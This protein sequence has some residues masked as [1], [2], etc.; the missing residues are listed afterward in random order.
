VIP[1]Q[2]TSG[3]KGN[4]HTPAPGGTVFSRTNQLSQHA[5]DDVYQMNIS[6]LMKKSTPAAQKHKI[7]DVAK[8]PDFGDRSGPATAEGQGSHKG[9]R[10]QNTSNSIQ[11]QRQNSEKSFNQSNTQNQKQVI[12]AHSNTD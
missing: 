11:Q 6:A 12:R 9:M 7:A 10:I 5:D 4:T 3:G 8:V 1:S 2:A